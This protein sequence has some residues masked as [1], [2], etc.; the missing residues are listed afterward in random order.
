MVAS[1]VRMRTPSA[2]FLS[3]GA[4]SLRRPQ[5]VHRFKDLAQSQLP[6]LSAL[7]RY[8]ASK[9]F[10]PHTIISMPALS[11][12]MNAGNIGVWQKKAGDALQPGDVLVE[13]ETDKA[14]MDFEFQEEGVLA[15]VLSETGE[16][17]VAV[18]TP[19]A[20]LVEE[21]TDVSAFESFSLE[22]AGSE[23]PAAGAA[24]SKS[25]SKEEAAPASSTPE[26]QPAAIEPET[27]GEKLQP[28]L[29]REANISPA[30]KALALEK[31][32]PLKAL[33]GTGRG[34]QITKEDVE[35][36]QPSVAAIAGA[37]YEDIPLTSMRKTIAS[38]LQQSMRENPHYFVSTTL[39]VTKLLKLRQALNASADGKY[40]LSVND[41][42]VK[43]CAAALLK[44]PAVNSSWREENGQ[45]V[46]RQHNTADISVAVATPNGLITPVVKNVQGL[47]LSSISNQIKDLGKRARDNKLKPE[48]Y[49][50]GTFTISNMGM[51]AAIERFTAVINPPQ[52]G[53]LAVGT[54]R[55]VAVPVETAEGTAVEWDDQIVVTGSFDHKV[56]DGA[57][58]AE[59]IKELKK[60]V[61]NPLELL[62]RAPDINRVYRDESES[63]ASLI[64]VDS[65]HVQSVDAD[66]LNQE[67]KTTTQA[68]RIEREEQ[69]AIAER[70]RIEKAKAKAKAEAKAKANRVRR[71]K[72][73][74]V[75]LGN[76]VILALTGAGLG[77]GAY[78]KH[79][80]GKLSWQLVGLWSGIVGAVGAVDYFVS[81]CQIAAS[82]ASLSRT[83]DDYSAL[84]KKELIPEK[85][86]KA[87]ERVKNFRT[88][89][90][91]YRLHFER[92]RKQREDAQSVTN[93]NELLGRRPHNTA[94]PE[95][96]YAQSSLPNPSPFGNPS[97][98]R[99]G[100][101]FGGGAADY[102]RETHAL[103]EQSFLANTGTQLDEFLDRG[104]AVLADLGQQ[105][106]VLKG[107][108]RRLYSVANTLG[109]SGETIRKVERRAKQDKWIF[110]VG[111]LIFFLFCWAVLHFLR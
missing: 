102:T 4:L 7:S 32:V 36:Y 44:V 18:G 85:Q 64:D 61:E 12:T 23:K 48:E 87:F 109:V 14:Q 101:G 8:Y 105:R 51:N 78:K 30:A 91:D 73:N 13:I 5:T 94:T 108:Q 21:G 71:N 84:S 77:F 89:L 57:V 104:R 75:Y 16:K 2:M 54:T 74:P 50:G 67:V 39:S 95:N 27:S 80:Q 47:G 110:W 37:T 92:L 111:V 72:S 28:A 96:P 63:T 86:E 17:D 82:L 99:S 59:W 42:L 93:R 53:I 26:P 40:K 6:S 41:F 49:Q 58:G 83:I 15:K 10:P 3:K 20:V 52:A 11:P 68:E 107:T 31:G 62:F 106:E 35:K 97:S 24:E 98:A 55:K 69:E 9:S 100:L 88:E 46:I 70:E 43:A 65:P 90:A 103:R 25:E 79:A 45:V 66:F 81:K 22:D 19:I 29:D 33:K 60:V 1:A 56:V 38:R 34:G 76:A